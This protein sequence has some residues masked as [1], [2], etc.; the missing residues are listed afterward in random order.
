MAREPEFGCSIKAP[1]MLTVAVI[2]TTSWSRLYFTNPPVKDMWA[3]I[4]WTVVGSDD[5]WTICCYKG[6]L[7]DPGGLMVGKALH[8]TLHG[9][10]ER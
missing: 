6:V 2:A 7:H 5:V 10:G 1:I 9:E 3:G 4:T 8:A